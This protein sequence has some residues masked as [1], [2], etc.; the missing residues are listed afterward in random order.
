MMKVKFKYAWLPMVV[1]TWRPRETKALIWLQ[2]YRI[3]NGE[4]SINYLGF[5]SVEFK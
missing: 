1:K 3:S 5:L 4:K 2:K